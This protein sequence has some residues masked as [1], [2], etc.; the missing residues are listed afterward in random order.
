M[1]NQNIIYQF[2]IELAEIEPTIW[3]VIQV[4]SKYTF[5]DFHVAI[6][7]VMKS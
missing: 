5:W 3:R 6:Q 1:K 4:P 7:G 2:K